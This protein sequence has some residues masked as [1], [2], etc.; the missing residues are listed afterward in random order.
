MKVAGLGNVTGCNKSW[1]HINNNGEQKRIKANE[2]RLREILR[3]SVENEIFYGRMWNEV[4]ELYERE[5]EKVERRYHFITDEMIEEAFKRS[6]KEGLDLSW[7]KD[8]NNEECIRQ[9]SGAFGIFTG[10]KY[11]SDHRIEAHKLKEQA[12]GALGG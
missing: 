12:K 11:A 5:K 2:E 10:A 8:S 6:H 9:Y 4:K 7:R 1:I 3:V